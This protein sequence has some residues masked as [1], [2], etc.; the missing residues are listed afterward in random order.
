MTYEKAHLTQI[1]RPTLELSLYKDP[2]RLFKKF[3]E[4]KNIKLSSVPGRTT[5]KRS[6]GLNGKSGQKFTLLAELTKS[7]RHHHKVNVNSNVSYNYNNNN[8]NSLN[9]SLNT[10][11][12]N[13]HHSY[14]HS[15]Q[16][17]TPIKNANDSKKVSLKSSSTPRRTS[18]NNNSSNNNN[19]NYTNNTEANAKS[20]IYTSFLEHKSANPFE[21]NLNILTK[22]NPS[23]YMGLA[24]D[25]GLIDSSINSRFA[26]GNSYMNLIDYSLDSRIL[27]KLL[28]S[29]SPAAASN[30]QQQINSDLQNKL[31]TGRNDLTNSSSK[32]SKNLFINFRK[33]DEK[34]ILKKPILEKSSSTMAM[35]KT[36][37]I[38]GRSST[39]KVRSNSGVKKSALP[40]NKHS[41]KEFSVIKSPNQSLVLNNNNNNPASTNNSNS[42]KK[43][44][45]MPEVTC[46]VYTDEAKYVYIKAWLDEVERVHAIEGKYLETINKITFYD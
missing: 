30:E 40:E 5:P 32:F 25:N 37:S 39:K 36:K 1:T 28:V 2:N 27:N 10:N 43:K 17:S 45:N 42:N 4:L 19:N 26:N 7:P 38:S 9:S 29:Q 16:N 6:M 44:E 46:R 13:Q 31:K 41:L 24:K 12:S 15:N 33:N 14:N 35:T 34:I 8:N 11:I 21:S 18:N 3:Q 20:R 23:F 22:S